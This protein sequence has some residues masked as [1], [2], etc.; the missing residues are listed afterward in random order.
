MPTGGFLECSLYIYT[1]HGATTSGCIVMSTIKSFIEQAD[2]VNVGALIALLLFTYLVYK[3]LALCST[4]E[5]VQDVITWALPVIL[6]I[7]S[8]YG[9]LKYIANS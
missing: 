8:T 9:I 1:Y 3:S 7:L 4:L 6:N 2:I 5:D